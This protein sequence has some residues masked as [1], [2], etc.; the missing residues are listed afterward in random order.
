MYKI[1]SMGLLASIMA[2]SIVTKDKQAIWVAISVIQLS[3]VS[4][5][6]ML[7]LDQ[8]ANCHSAPRR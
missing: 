5:L 6:Y 3:V 7:C 4:I 1:N 8:L 2:N